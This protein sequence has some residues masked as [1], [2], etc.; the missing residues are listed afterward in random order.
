M[1]RTALVTGAS[2]VALLRTLRLSEHA[3]PASRLT[4]DRRA[5]DHCF[6]LPAL[7]PAARQ[8]GTRTGAACPRHR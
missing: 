6:D 7:L 4:L 2:S 8:R 5:D 3:A 1:T